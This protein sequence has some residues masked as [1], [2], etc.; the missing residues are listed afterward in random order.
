[1][2]DENNNDERP[3]RSE[4]P[5]RRP[6]PQDG[7]SSKSKMISVVVGIIVVLVALL[8][9]TRVSQRQLREMELEQILQQNRAQE[10]FREKAQ[11]RRFDTLENN[12]QA[13]M[14]ESQF[15]P[16]NQTVHPREP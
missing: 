1:M 3:E 16:M 10:T 14:L 12:K 15:K 2:E 11:Q 6:S 4:G 7:D 5:S 9:F 8:Q 13:E